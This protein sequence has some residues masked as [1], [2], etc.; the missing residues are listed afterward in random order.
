[1]LPAWCTDCR[2]TYAT[3]SNP[4]RQPRPH[5]KILL[6]LHVMNGFAGLRQQKSRRLAG[7]GSRGLEMSLSKVNA[8]HV[9]GQA[10]LIA[11]QRQKNGFEVSW[12]ERGTFYL[13]FPQH[14]SH[15]GTRVNASSSSQW[16]RRII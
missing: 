8:G 7:T 11:D 15:N 4:H 16:P 9:A 2:R 13:P 14:S 12:T 10:V 3:P 5:G 6:R 1:M